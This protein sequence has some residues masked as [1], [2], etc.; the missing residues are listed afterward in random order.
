MSVSP[1]ER[2]AEAFASELARWR[3]DRG[4]TKKQLAARMGFD[5]SYISHIEG[6]RHRPT[7]EFARRAEA[8]L[9]ARGAIWRRFQEYA[10]AR[11]ARAPTTVLAREPAVPNQWLPPG[12]G[13]V[14]ELE[15]AQL[16]YAE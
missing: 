6:R 3:V 1:V 11:Q 8:V 9:S 5:P 2:A 4:M 12:A 13:L 10:E 7:E 15:E 14:V 16:T